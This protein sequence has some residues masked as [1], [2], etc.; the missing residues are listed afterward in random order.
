MAL[1][2][3]LLPLTERFEAVKEIADFFE[4]IV[5]PP[6][7]PNSKDITE[8]TKR[9]VRRYANDVTKEQLEEELRH[10]AK[11]GQDLVT[12]RNKA[13][14]LLNGIYEK[15]AENLYPQICICL[16]IFLSVPV[17]VALGERCFS[18]FALIKDCRRSSMKQQRLTNLMI[19]SAEHKLARSINFDRL[20]SDFATK[21]SVKESIQLK[22]VSCFTVTRIFAFL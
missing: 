6:V 15:R 5:N 16:R 10:Y 14:A 18:K 11:F 8:Q 9:L 22:I 3:L 13:L 17:S 20:I 4:F 7:N 19:L 12:I 1:D 2:T 21:K